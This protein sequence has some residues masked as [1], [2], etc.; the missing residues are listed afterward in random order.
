[1]MWFSDRL[2]A[3]VWRCRVFVRAAAWLVPRPQREAWRSGQQ[4]RFW[5]WC[6]FLSES[7]QFTAQNRLLV[8]GACWHLFPEAFWLRYDR[9]RFR[10]GVRGVAGSPAFL[11]AAL[12][13]A[14]TLILLGS[15]I[16]PATRLAFSQP[17]AHADRV[18]VITLDGSGIN[19]KYSRTRSDTLLDLSSIWA[20][21]R[22]SE[23]LAPFSWGPA[24]LLLPKRDLPIA[25][26]RVG[27]RF[28]ATLGA[29]AALGRVF[30]PNDIHE[31]PTCVV[32]NYSLWQHELHADPT[33]IGKQVVLN[34]TPHLV[35]GV[36]PANFRMISPGIVVWG[37]IEPDT[38]FT[39][40]QRRV[41]AVALLRGNA[42]PQQFQSDLSD[43]TE[44]AGYVHPSSQ[45]QVV[46]V[47]ALVRRNLVSV[48]WFLLLAVCC[49]ALVVVLRLSSNGFGSLP[50][51]SGARTV[52][53]GFFAVKSVL[54]LALVALVSWRLVHWIADGIAGSAYPLSDEYS[55]WLF[56]PLA[57]V[58]LSWSVRD[59]QRRCRTCLRRLELPVEIGRTGSVLLNW[60]GTEMVCP[61][62]HGILYL[63]ESPANS[64][65]QG[66]WSTLDGSWQ[67]LFARDQ[68]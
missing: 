4:R 24:N 49:A 37:L 18:V 9:D 48:L 8:A 45:L 20:Q 43:L 16:I 33:I 61:L 13:I 56:L 44:S 12:S 55:I 41:G 26:A 39:N 14:V 50:E 57:I 38:L 32:L 59:Q 30:L 31:C 34:G 58:A 6:H 65:D 35:I 67:E 21:S 25:T 66:R 63:P 47:A 51:R 23:G 29:K 62:G 10:G 22:L 36:L 54:V 27:P 46:T 7:G 3:T 64:L 11:L 53:L 40:F 60:A 28:F 5:H 42:T 52:W 19:G 17:V 2:R 1:M 15:G 68:E